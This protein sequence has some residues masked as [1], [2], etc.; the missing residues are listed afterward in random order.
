M[1]VVFQASLTD[2][3]RLTAKGQ[4][5]D[6][7]RLLREE[8]IRKRV[9]KEKPKVEQHNLVC[10][11]R[12]LKD[13]LQ[14]ENDLLSLIPA[15]EHENNQPFLVNGT[16]FVEDLTAKLEMDQAGRGA[17]SKVSYTAN[18]VITSHRLTFFRNS[19]RKRQ[20]RL[21]ALHHLS[22]GR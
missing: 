10:A 5:G 16:R 11:R 2:P 12:S 7:G 13:I 9:A 3:A 22:S 6:P 18:V 14:L 8:K 21:Q 15:W 4:R 19:A 17:A 20:S 1:V